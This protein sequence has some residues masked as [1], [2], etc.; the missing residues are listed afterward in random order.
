MCDSSCKTFAGTHFW[1]T[2]HV[3]FREHSTIKCEP[4]LRCEVGESGSGSGVL[5]C[6]E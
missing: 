4:G 2:L 1:S 5:C 3:W 6:V